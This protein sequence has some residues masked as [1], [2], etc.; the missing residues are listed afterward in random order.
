MFVIYFKGYL[1]QVLLARVPNYGRTVPLALYFL[2]ELNTKF[3]VNL[4]YESK[5]RKEEQGI[6]NGKKVETKPS[7]VSKEKKK[8]LSY[9]RPSVSR[10]F[11]ADPELFTVF[12]NGHN[13]V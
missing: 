13:A 10:S 6:K 9:L 7:R 4:A 3:Q 2:C 8:F 12:I 11:M 5:V 1:Q